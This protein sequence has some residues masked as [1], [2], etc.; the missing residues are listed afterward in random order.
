[1]LIYSLYTVFSQLG[2]IYVYKGIW[3]SGGHA[4]FTWI[5][6]LYILACKGGAKHQAF[7]VDRRSSHHPGLRPF[8]WFHLVPGVIPDNIL[9]LGQ[10]DSLRSCRSLWGFTLLPTS[11]SN[12][13]TSPH[14][15]VMQNTFLV[16]TI[17]YLPKETKTANILLWSMVGGYSPALWGKYGIGTWGDLFTLCLQLS[18]IS[19]PQPMGWCFLQSMWIFAFSLNLFGNALTVMPGGVYPIYNQVNV[20]VEDC[21]SWWTLR[22]T[23]GSHWTHFKLC[24]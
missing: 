3:G 12:G 21:T 24:I 1:M 8:A 22:L 5:C 16:A 7:L 15:M 13:F 19:K 9:G 23:F 4:L 18:R 2:Y 14:L 11:S 6:L 17:K 10:E 20:T